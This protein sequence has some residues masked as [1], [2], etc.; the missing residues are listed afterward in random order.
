MGRKLAGMGERDDAA[1]LL[2]TIVQNAVTDT[3]STW[4]SYFNA[5]SHRIVAGRA[6]VGELLGAYEEHVLP[7]LAKTMVILRKFMGFG[8]ALCEP[9]LRKGGFGLFNVGEQGGILGERDI[10]SFNDGKKMISYESD[11]RDENR[12]RKVA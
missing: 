10:Q 4:S 3:G 12:P 9:T 1:F 7:L 8:T 6:T 5:S 2:T 11:S